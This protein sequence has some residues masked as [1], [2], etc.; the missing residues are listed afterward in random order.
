KD[1]APWLKAIEKDGLTWTNHVSD[2]KYWQSVA[3][4]SY[5]VNGIPAT[6]LLDK[7]GRVIAKNL[8]GEELEKKLEEVFK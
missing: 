7:E 4:Q 8:R 6:F 1:K 5:G 2:L 3:A